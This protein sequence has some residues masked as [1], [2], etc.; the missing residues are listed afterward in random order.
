VNKGQTGF[1]VVER[2]GGSSNGTFDYRVVAKRKGFES[3]RLDYCKAAE[4]DSY[5]YPELREQELREFK[6][7]RAKLEREHHLHEETRAGRDDQN[8]LIERTSSPILN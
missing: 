6:E 2:Q 7:K 5:L 8:V 1:D 4:K 3:R